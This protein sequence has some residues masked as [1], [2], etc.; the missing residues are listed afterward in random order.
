MEWLRY[1]MI[2]EGLTVARSS[3]GGMMNLFARG[4]GI[5]RYDKM[6]GGYEMTHVE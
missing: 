5:P 2:C 4:G 6:E 3:C 1:E